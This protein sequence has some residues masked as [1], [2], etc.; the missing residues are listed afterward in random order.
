MIFL[1]A[2][3]EGR[4]DR[5]PDPPYC[6]K[7]IGFLC[8][9]CADPLKNHKATKPAFNVGPS[10]ALQRNAISMSF[11]WRADDGL[12]KEVFEFSTPPQSIK[13]INIKFEPPLK[14]LSG[15]LHVSFI[16]FCSLYLF[17]LSFNDH[18]SILI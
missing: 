13:K 5:G 15:S 4:G 3:S 8:K 7:N 12:I 14:K 6:L 1:W 2:G 11:R 18:K 10:S 16:I 9:T 17:R